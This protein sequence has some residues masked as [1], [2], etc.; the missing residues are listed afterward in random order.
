MA[1]GAPSSSPKS[2]ARSAAVVQNIEV[3]VTTDGAILRDVGTMGF[4]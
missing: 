2:R 1:D 3:D 4:A